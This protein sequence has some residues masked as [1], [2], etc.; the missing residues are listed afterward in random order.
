MREL[1]RTEGKYYLRPV[2]TDKGIKDLKVSKKVAD[3][4]IKELL[5]EDKELLEI[6][7]KL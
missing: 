1:K 3:K 4:Q 6:L 5:K 2:L 7:E